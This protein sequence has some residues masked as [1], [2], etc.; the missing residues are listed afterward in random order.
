VPEVKNFDD[1]P[2]FMDAVINPNRRMEQ[3]ANSRRPRYTRAETRE[4]LK[5]LDVIQESGSKMFGCCD[6]ISADVVE[7]GL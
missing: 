2:V 7:N 6:V 3:F 5:M 1:L 4:I